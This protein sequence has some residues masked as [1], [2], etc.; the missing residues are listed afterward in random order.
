M[1]EVRGAMMA[2]NNYDHEGMNFSVPIK[3]ARIISD[4]AA[5]LN[6]PT[7]L[8]HAALQHYYAAMAQG[9][10][11]QDAAAVCRV[12]ESAAGATRPATEDGA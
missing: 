3:D 9:F 11:D 2:N 1:L 10:G 8:Y 12:L 5:S 7:P 6:C 4:H